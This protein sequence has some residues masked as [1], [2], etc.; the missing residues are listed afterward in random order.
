[1]RILLPQLGAP[2]CCVNKELVKR[3]AHTAVLYKKHEKCDRGRWWVIYRHLA[4]L[5]TENPSSLKIQV[6]L[7]LLILT[8]ALSFPKLPGMHTG[9]VKD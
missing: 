5:S 4:N 2:S 1:M 6:P 8:S 9:D 7:K 3:A